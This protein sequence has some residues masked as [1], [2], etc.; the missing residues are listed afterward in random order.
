MTDN[1]RAEADASAE[2]ALIRRARRARRDEVAEPAAPVETTLIKIRPMARPARFRLRHKGLLLTF[3]IMVL[4]PPLAALWY[5]ETRAA[6][7]FASSIGFTVRSEELQSA[8]DFLG[9]VGAA[10]GGGGSKDSDILYEFIRSQELVSTVQGRLDLEAL[11]SRH[12]VS[13]PLFGFAPDGTIEDLTDY[14]QRMVRI[15]YDSGSGLMELR[16]LAF[17][18]REAQAIAETIFDE[19]SIMINALSAVARED[20]TA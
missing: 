8:T 3:V 15:S 7:Q 16:V 9:G 20:A 14:W 13:D 2:P 12:H 4:I 6:P 17:S 19:S 11:F 10:L 5:L 1:T 18:P